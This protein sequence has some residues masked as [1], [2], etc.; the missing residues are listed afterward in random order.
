MM[1]RIFRQIV[2]AIALS[3]AGCDATKQTT[4]Q[5]DLLNPRFEDGELGWRFYFQ[6][7]AGKVALNA[8][9]LDSSGAHLT[10]SP[11]RQLDGFSQDVSPHGA[12]EIE[13]SAY[14]K[15]TGSDIRCIVRIECL[16][17]DMESE[18]ENYGQLAAIDSSPC[19]TND[20]WNLL[21]ARVSIPAQTKLIRVF[22]C[23][24]GTNGEA[25]FDEFS[26]TRR[27]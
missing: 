27:R 10:L 12:A 4:T 16:D 1:N 7:S 24:E 17:P 5:V 26:V 11:S 19:P 23:V 8:G 20:Q 21:V 3:S 2:F 6:E 22:A 9:I 14:A 13:A 15:V 25:S 18:T